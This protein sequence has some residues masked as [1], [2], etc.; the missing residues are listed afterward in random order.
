GDAA[1]GGPLATG[2]ALAE[3]YVVDVGPAQPGP[4]DECGE[5]VGGEGARVEVAEHAA[6]AADGGG[7]G[8][9]DDDVTH[10]VLLAVRGRGSE[11][12][13]GGI[14]GERPRGGEDL[15]DELAAE[16]FAV[17]AGRVRG[18]V[19]RGHHAA[20]AVVDGRGERAQTRLELL[21]DH[22]PAAFGH[23][24]ELGAQVLPVGEPVGGEG[25][26]IGLGEV[27]VELVG[28]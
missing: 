24:V 21:V 2:G 10:G 27:G 18:H 20:V 5:E 23:G 14:G 26:E 7:E 4:F 9:A 12:D 3:D 1:D 15:G 17:V 28:R 6:E 19:E 16:V 11:V 8:V 22:A 13:G 25:A